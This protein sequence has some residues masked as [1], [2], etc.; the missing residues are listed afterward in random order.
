MYL[1]RYCA[2]LSGITI[3]ESWPSLVHFKDDTCSIVPI[4]SKILMNPNW[5]P[6]NGFDTGISASIDTTGYCN[7]ENNTQIPLV[8]IKLNYIRERSLSLLI[9]LNP[10]TYLFKPVRVWSI[11]VVFHLKTKFIFTDWTENYQFIQHLKTCSHNAIATAI[12]LLRII[13][14]IRFSDILAIIP[15]EQLHWIP[16]NPQNAIQNRCRNRILWTD[17]QTDLSGLRIV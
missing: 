13:S 1:S 9:S 10:K 7:W 4:A 15:C 12:Y 5:L 2:G 14:C 6:L 16:Y 17:F 8:F 3:A 11:L